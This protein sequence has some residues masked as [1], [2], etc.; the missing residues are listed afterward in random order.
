MN[1]LYIS[2]WVKSVLL[3][4]MDVIFWNIKILNWSEKNWIIILIIIII[5]LG[6]LL[7]SYIANT[8]CT[9]THTHPHTHTSVAIQVVAVRRIGGAMNRGGVNAPFRQFRWRSMARCCIIQINAGDSVFAIV[10]GVFRIWNISRPNS[11]ANSW[12]E[13]LS[14]DTNSSRHF[15]RRSSKNC[16]LQFANCDRQT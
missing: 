7:L 6:Q 12:E 1:V 3:L 9:H 4:Y 5:S 13:V 11:D 10:L 8:S 15:P 14:V 16:D 2:F